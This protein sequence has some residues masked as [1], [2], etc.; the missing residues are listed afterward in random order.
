MIR[1]A[2]AVIAIIPTIVQV[3]GE[4]N[5]PLFNSLKH[6]LKGQYRACNHWVVE[7]AKNR[8]CPQ[9]VEAV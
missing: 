2:P 9:R 7:G 1:R 6:T 4:G 8:Q 5:S 3:E